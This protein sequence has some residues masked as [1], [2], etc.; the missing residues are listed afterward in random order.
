MS[1]RICLRLP[2]SSL[3]GIVLMALPTFSF[4]QQ[5]AAEEFA[6][7]VVRTVALPL[8]AIEDAAG[9]RPKPRPQLVIGDLSEAETEC[10]QRAWGHVAGTAMRIYAWGGS[11][12][13]GFDDPLSYWWDGASG[14]NVQR[15]PPAELVAARN[16][17]K[18][19]VDGE[20][21]NEAD[22]LTIEAIVHRTGDPA[23]LQRIVRNATRETFGAILVEVLRDAVAAVGGAWS[24]DGETG[25]QALSALPA[26]AVG[27]AY[28]IF[29]RSCTDP[30]SY[31]KDVD[32]AWNAFPQLAWFPALVA[33][34]T[35]E[36]NT[37]RSRLATAASLN[38]VIALTYLTRGT[39]CTDAGTVDVEAA[40]ALA[41]RFPQEAAAHRALALNWAAAGNEMRSSRA[42][43]MG[44]ADLTSGPA[45]HDPRLAAAISVSLAGVRAWPYQ[46]RWWWTLAWVLERYAGRMRG[47]LSWHA[48]PA[49]SKQRYSPL[50]DL[51]RE[52][53]DRALRINPEKPGIWRLRLE[54]SAKLNDDWWRDFEQGIAV[55]PQF[56]GL[57]R[58]AFHYSQEQW[59]GTSAKRASV[60]ALA[61]K[62][63]PDASWPLELYSG[64]APASE[65]RWHAY[66]GRW[67]GLLVVVLGA[68]LFMAR[69]RQR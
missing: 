16:G 14:A 31:A 8:P 49:E 19:Y 35:C 64:Y 22:Q 59:G 41:R 42:N 3:V 68:G 47:D 10:A 6:G 15:R 36:A 23:P 65:V 60:Y 28:D 58:S 24:A 54:L 53:A 4:A 51:A 57:Y 29:V 56:Y 45:A 18:W 21:R 63:N 34:S 38:P 46:Y 11:P 39:D 66:R 9:V 20:I 26:D 25:L 40:K 33:D 30:E 17:A 27:R 62:N 48:M 44:P 67:I 1:M 50:N 32:E 61:S 13:L 69:R 12:D 2:V 7:R 37:R 55:G 5:A 43:P 52:A